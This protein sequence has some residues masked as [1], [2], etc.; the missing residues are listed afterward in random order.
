MSLTNDRDD[1]RL[2]QT[3]PDGQQEAYLVLSKEE[4]AKGFIRPVRTRYQHVG[5]RP[6]GATRALTE[7][8]EE[9]FKT[10]NYLLY[11]EYSDPDSA[12][13]GRFWTAEQLKSGCGVVTQMAQELAETYA[14]D[15][16][17]YGS[18][19]CVGCSAHIRVEEFVWEGTDERVG[20]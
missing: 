18:T 9:R 15:P 19:F 6:T 17:H 7:E 11:E 3:R 2:K 8:E 1:P 12:V 20:S 14:R 10:Q 5:L 16:R 4:R 13:C